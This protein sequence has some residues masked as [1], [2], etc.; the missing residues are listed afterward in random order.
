MKYNGKKL[1]LVLAMVLFVSI[2]V[3]WNKPGKDDDRNLKVLPKN[4]SSD[5]LERV[6]DSFI[7]ALGVDCGFCH[8]PKDPQQ[9][10]KPDYSSDAN[11]VKDIT[12]TMMRMTDEMNHKYMKRLPNENVQFITCNTCHKGEPMPAKY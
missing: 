7:T 9:P 10:K 11:Q 3:S 12:R 1:V 2:L 8:A 4:I 6:M 5:S